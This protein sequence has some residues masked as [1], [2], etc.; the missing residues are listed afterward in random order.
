[1]AWGK[2]D[3]VVVMLS[4]RV[5]DVRS[6]DSF[7]A[8]PYAHRPLDPPV[9]HLRQM[10]TLSL[11]L[12]AFARHVLGDVD[13]PLFKLYS[14]GGSAYDFPSRPRLPRHIVGVSHALGQRR[15]RRPSGVRVLV[16]DTATTSPFRR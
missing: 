6:S 1:M 2:P 14:L 9:G 5:F 4:E 10:R 8:S 11:S 3:K 12:L 15:R 7:K 13:Y 16:E